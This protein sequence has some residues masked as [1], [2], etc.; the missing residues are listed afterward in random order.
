MNNSVQ[1]V[2]RQ[3]PSVNKILQDSVMKS[4]I[5]DYGEKLVKI[6]INSVLGE[7]KSNIL[8]GLVDNIPN[9]DDIVN[10][11][12]VEVNSKALPSLRK[13]INGTGII[14]HTNL[15]R[16]SLP[17]NVLN[18]M[19]R[20]AS[21]YSNLEFDLETGKRGSRYAHVAGLISKITGAED[22]VVVNNNAAA[23][24]LVLSTLASKGDVVISRGELVEIGGSFRVP[25]IITS[26][27]GN[28][29]EVGT[30]N[31]TH[32]NDYA[33]KI[34]EETTALLKV[35]TSNYKVIGF[36]EG[37]STQELHQLA[38][39]NNLPLIVDL[40]SGLLVD[41]SKYINYKEPTVQEMVKNSDIVTFSGDKLLGGPQIGV[42]AGKKKYIDKIKKNQLLRALRVDKLT[43]S[44]LE[45][46]LREYYLKDEKEL[47]ASIPVLKKLTE[48][49][50]NL[51]QKAKDLLIILKANNKLNLKI[52]E[53][54]SKVGGGSLPGLEL[55]TYLVA[56][57]AEGISVN[58][59]ESR[60]RKID[61]PIIGRTIKD[62]FCLDLRTIEENEYEII[63]DGLCRIISN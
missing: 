47:L 59:L 19:Q 7:I 1:L 35:H 3:I 24:M 8:N 5:A 34:N 18:Q 52:I 63:K 54:Y 40:G 20:I 58:K 37:V 29:V 45:I 55:P 10:Q 13:V 48:S 49:S 23:V 51:E 56:I 4:I 2:L 39:E 36:T 27:G 28:L 53:D 33:E 9:Y 32:L 15:G 57:K 61:I 11:I 6:S 12:K 62:Y 30:T 25:E 31:K 38:K 16:A 41:L 26:T 50:D 14:L 42:I 21:G 17:E 22:A 43:L 44:S 60:L 46:I